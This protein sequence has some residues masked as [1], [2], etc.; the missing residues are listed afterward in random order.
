MSLEPQRD[1][2][3]TT[4]PSVYGQTPQNSKE[5]VKNTCVRGSAHGHL[6]FLLTSW[7][8]PHTA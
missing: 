5:V 7:K 4:L 1:N 3:H 2:D 6:T 8:R